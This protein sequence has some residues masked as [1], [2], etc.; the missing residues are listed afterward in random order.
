MESKI[1]T[2]QEMR[3][4]ANLEKNVWGNTTTAEMLS[5]AAAIIEREENREVKYEY[6]E[7]KN[8]IITN[9]H[10]DDIENY[11]MYCDGSI[12]V[13]RPIGEWEEVK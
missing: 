5:Q 4:R 11:V 9:L 1:Y 13:R 10:S 7:S 2:A 6:A 8:G 12:L 3:I